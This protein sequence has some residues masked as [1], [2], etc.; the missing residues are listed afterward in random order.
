MSYK[1]WVYKYK[2]LKTEETEIEELLVEYTAQ[3]KK[4]F[5]TVKDISSPN[6]EA[7]PL[8]EDFI[9][10]E[11]HLLDEENIE[12]PPKKRKDL[13]KKLS[14]KLHP[15]RGGDENEFKDLTNLYEEEDI[16]G[17]YVKA[18]ELGLD[19]ILKKEDEETFEVTCDNIQEKIEFYKSTAAWKWGTVREE[20]KEV[21]SFIIEQQANVIRRNK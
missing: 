19:F 21:L 4:D 5:K 6:N 18:E 14:K 17:M 13:Y 1:K 3:F 2:Y 8:K 20:E 12:K 15:D 16:L 9:N 7:P 10:E 11:N